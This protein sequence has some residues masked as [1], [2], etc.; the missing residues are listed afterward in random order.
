VRGLDTEGWGWDTLPQKKDF[1][2]GNQNSLR[3]A[4]PPP[5]EEAEW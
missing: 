3:D 4:A 2:I 1:Y 5:P